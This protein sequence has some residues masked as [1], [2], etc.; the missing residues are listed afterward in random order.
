MVFFKREILICSCDYLQMQLFF[1]FFCSDG[2]LLSSAHKRIIHVFMYSASAPYIPRRAKSSHASL[3]TR[4]SLFSQLSVIYLSKKPLDL[5]TF[6]VHFSERQLQSALSLSP[7]GFT[8][9]GMGMLTDSNSCY[10]KKPS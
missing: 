4:F 1:F 5:T 3:C 10:G 2:Y 9:K 8:F 7:P 6:I